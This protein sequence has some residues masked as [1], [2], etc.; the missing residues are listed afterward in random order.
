M[1]AEYKPSELVAMVKAGMPGL[2]VAKSNIIAWAKREG[3]KGRDYELRGQTMF[4]KFAFLPAASRGYLVNPAP[5]AVPVPAVATPAPLPAITTPEALKAPAELKE[6]QRIPM[7]ARVQLMLKIETSGQVNKTIRDIVAAAEADPDNQV[8]RNANFRLGGKSKPLSVSTLDKW[9]SAWQRSKLTTP[10]GKPNYMVLA[11][12]DVEN[13]QEPI[14]AQHV[15]ALYNRPQKPSVPQALEE[16]AK[17]LPAGVPLPTKDQVYHY[18][19]KRGVLESNKGRMTGAELKRIKG[20]SIRD[21]SELL[22]LQVVLCD[23]HSG[24][25][26]V[27][28]PRHGRHFHPEICFAIDAATKVLIGWSTGLAESQQTV[29]DAIRHGITLK[30]VRMKDGRELVVGGSITILYTDK[31]AGNCADLN[32]AP[33][34][35]RFARVGITHETG[36]AGNPRGRGM[37]EIVNRTVWIPMMKRLPSYTGKDMDRLV[38]RKVWDALEK[39]VKQ[40]KKEQRKPESKYLIS[41]ESFLALV[42]EAVDDYNNRPHRSLPKTRD[43]VTGKVRH[44]T[45]LEM[46]ARFVDQ[47]WQPDII[48]EKDLEDLFKPHEEVATRNAWISLW[49]N[50]YYHKALEHYHGKKVIAEYDIHDGSK[51]WVRD[52]EDRRLICVAGF[53]ANKR[54][55]FPKSKIEKAEEDR[56]KSKMSRIERRAEDA[57]LEAEPVLAVVTEHSPEIKE[58]CLR[59][60]QQLQIEEAQ[61]VEW[62]PPT[63]DQAR[64]RCWQDFDARLQAGETLPDAQAGWFK[65]WQNSPLCRSWLTL[66]KEMGQ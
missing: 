23:G 48:A 4:I 36:I 52:R 29:A 44:M 40:S 11:P 61:V 16:L 17:L 63:E 9:W 38:A 49:G 32:S 2:P 25:G 22:P 51:L 42:Q 7:D 28:H 57:R 24:K 13:Y 59:I 37:V 54:S 3:R 1:K 34:I 33:E 55:F 50:R 39:E 62:E 43:A 10:D 21:T 26:Y 46:W 8:F 41:W 47:G 66:R 65:A 6:W 12:K 53:E 5:A 31:G 60:A 18:N 35:G 15:T 27:A 45:P 56:L 19:K 20:Y 14:W 30:I 64:L 58:T